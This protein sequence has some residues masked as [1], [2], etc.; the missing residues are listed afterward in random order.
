M[1]LAN[2]WII[3][4]LL[5]KNG[6]E[7]PLIPNAREI[8]QATFQLL[9]EGGKPRVVT[10][11]VLTDEQFSEINRK[12]AEMGLHPLESPE[13]VL[14]GRHLYKSRVVQNHYTIDDICDQIE[15]ALS[16]NS[17]PILGNKMT[18]LRNNQPRQ[19]RYGN[20][21][22]DEA[23][24]ELTQRR[25]KA[26]LFLSSLRGT[27]IVLPLCKTTEKQKGLSCERPFWK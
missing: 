19:D 9:A 3:G 21:V 7:M 5:K 12:R 1:Q 15:S 27:G 24:L 11:G 22:K 17:V 20:Q 16:P 10:I 6:Q 14:L 13:I 18:A 26:E 4:F 23:I 25:P 2:S 8:L